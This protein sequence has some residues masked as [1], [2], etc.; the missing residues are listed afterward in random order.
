M[1]IIL[2]ALLGANN[3]AAPATQALNTLTEIQIHQVASRRINT[4]N[5][6][7][8]NGQSTI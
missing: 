6:A 1:I 3:F 4:S 2:L 7:N 8:E 5:L